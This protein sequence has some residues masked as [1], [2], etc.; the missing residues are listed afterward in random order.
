M[1]IP[2]S[3][4]QRDV[5]EAIAFI[6]K[7]PFG[8]LISNAQ[9]QILATHLPFVVEQSKNKLTLY[10]HLSSVNRQHATFNNKEQVLIVFSEPHTYISPTLYEH[11]QS[12]PTW[13]YIAVHLYGK[14][15]IA[16]N[17]EEKIS[18]LMKQMQSYESSYIEQFKKMSTTYTNNMLNA[19]VAIQINIDEWQC[20]E[21]LSQNKSE[22]DRAT[23]KQYLLS[24]NDSNLVYL[25]NKMK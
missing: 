19:I 15:K 17:N 6:E 7:Y 24:E 22:K 16:K 10:T 9:Q 2:Q 23:I 4:E 21:K 18:I 13:N 3:F 12:V 20:Q 14:I 25:A 1:H 8:I 11:S 5:K